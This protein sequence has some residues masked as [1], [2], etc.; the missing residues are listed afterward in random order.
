MTE[1]DGTLTIALRGELD[2]AWAGEAR[3]AFDAARSSTATAVR[4]DLT[5]LDFVDSTGLRELVL[6][7]QAL[8]RSGRT[9]TCTPGGPAVQRVLAVSGLLDVLTFEDAATPPPTPT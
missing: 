6:L 4:V 8:V 7:H 9:L 1:A 3:A 2:L 5:A